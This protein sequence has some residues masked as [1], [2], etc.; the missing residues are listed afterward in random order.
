VDKISESKDGFGGRL[1]SCHAQ[2]SEPEQYLNCCGDTS[3]PGAR[4][5]S[6]PLAPHDEMIFLYNPT[7]PLIFY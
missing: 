7:F 1:H 2:P 6:P 4:W 3:E 5:L